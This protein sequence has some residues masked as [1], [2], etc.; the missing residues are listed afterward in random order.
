MRPPERVKLEIVRLPLLP[1]LP[2]AMRREKW[3]KSGIGRE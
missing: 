2:E 3:L 1:Q